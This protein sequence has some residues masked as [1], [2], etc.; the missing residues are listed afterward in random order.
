[1]EQR[2]RTFIRGG[3][4]AAAVWAL[5]LFGVPA[6]HADG[7]L[8]LGKCSAWGWSTGGTTLGA[9]Q[10]AIADCARHDAEDCKVVAMTHEGCMAVATDQSQSC[11][12]VY[13]ANEATRRE[14]EN[15]S[16][17][18]CKNGDSKSCTLVASKCDRVD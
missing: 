8:A 10:K 14:A 7:A 5:L 4:A 17:G 13:W 2:V 1:M 11:G 15:G 6:A 18:Q 9:S 12:K 3:S 16:L